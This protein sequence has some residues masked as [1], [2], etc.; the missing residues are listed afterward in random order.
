MQRAALYEIFSQLFFKPDNRKREAAESF[1]KI[2]KADNIEIEDFDPGTLEIEYNRL[3]VGPGHVPCPPYESVYRKDRP[4]MDRGLVMGPSAIDVEKRYRQAGLQKSKDFHDLPDHI[5]V[6][7][8]FMGYLCE[9]EA[10]DGAKKW[11]KMQ[12]EFLKL[13]IKPWYIEFLECIKKHSRSTFY[14]AAATELKGFIEEELEGEN[15]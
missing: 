4:L 6:E 12:D 5:G 15:P 8:E 11:R 1:I 7:M 9:M 2:A 10:K 14:S 3:F 13:H